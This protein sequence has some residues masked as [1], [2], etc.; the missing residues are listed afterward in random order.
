[1][2]TQPPAL[3]KNPFS[4]EEEPD[5]PAF[6]GFGGFSS[7][8]SLIDIIVPMKPEELFSDHFRNILKANDSQISM[9]VFL[10]GYQCD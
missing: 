7:Q 3:N 5:A 2:Q 10:V 8:I 9:N 1:V 6:G 4:T